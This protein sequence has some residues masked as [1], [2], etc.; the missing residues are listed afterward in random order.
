[1]IDPLVSERVGASA[2]LPL[3]RRRDDEVRPLGDG[4]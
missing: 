2:V 3:D 4:R 1:M